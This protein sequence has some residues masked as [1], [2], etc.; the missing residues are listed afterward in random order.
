[1]SFLI[2]LSITGLAATLLLGVAADV[3][4]VRSTFHAVAGFLFACVA[5]GTLFLAWI[6]LNRLHAAL[7]HVAPG[8]NWDE[9]L[10]EAWGWRPLG[11]QEGKE[12]EP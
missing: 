9:I 12:E 4:M 6:Q 3:G 10:R 8:Q 11:Q 1:M 7:R 2:W 5:M